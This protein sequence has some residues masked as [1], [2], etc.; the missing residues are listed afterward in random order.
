MTKD[1]KIEQV[2]GLDISDRWSHV[3]RISMASGEVL[4]ESRVRTDLESIE[5]LFGGRSRLRIVLEVGPHSPW[6][7]RLLEE[8]GHEV[9]VAHAR[10]VG[11]V[12]A[13]RRKNDRVD[14]KLLARL[15]RLDPEL[16]WPIRH[17]S[18][19]A[20]H[21]LAV[22]RSRDAAVRSRTSLINHVRGTVKATG[23]RLP[24]CSAAAFARKVREQIPE[25]LRPALSPLVDLIERLSEEIRGYDRQIRALC[26]RYPE[27]SRLQQVHGVGP[28]SSLAYVLVLED[29][30][31]FAT[32]RSVGAF[33][34]MVPKSDESGESSPQL[35]ITKEGDAL[36]RRLM[37]QCA[38]YILGPFGQDCDLRRHG[39]KLCLR[40]GATTKKKAAVAVGRK[41]AVLLH[42]LWKSGEVYDPLYNAKRQEASKTKRRTA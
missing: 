9:I 12:V 20:Q 39:Q 29:P 33:L 31:R 18:P 21:D 7:S 3:H 10:K 4:Q 16:L 30:G 15:G 17:R 24:S 11:L 27:T 42:R 35:R 1:S 6:M 32:S 38:H 41:L 34:G 8:L 36:L 19:R 40:G 28:L 2:V 5:A 23:R 26:R 25:P 37:L 22:I 14:A 13:N